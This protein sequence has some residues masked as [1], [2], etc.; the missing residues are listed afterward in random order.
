MP[1]HFCHVN[2]KS[3]PKQY[4]ELDLYLNSLDMEFSFLAFTETW[5]NEANND[6]YAWPG[7]NCINKY[8]KGRKGGG[9][10]LAIQNQITYKARNY[11][12]HFD[13]KWNLYS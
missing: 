4:D 1:C 2:V 13:V 9:V 7:Y 8:R 12:E 11:L 10:P 6:L 3:L 5:L